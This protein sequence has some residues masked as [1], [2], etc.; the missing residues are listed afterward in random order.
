M[1]DKRDSGTKLPGLK[2]PLDSAMAGDISNCSVHKIKILLP[3]FQIISN[4]PINNTSNLIIMFYLLSSCL[5]RP[6]EVVIFSVFINKRTNEDLQQ[7]KLK[8][9][10]YS[11]F[12]P[13]CDGE[14]FRLKRTFGHLSKFRFGVLTKVKSTSLWL[15]S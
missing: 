3:L 11:H 7:V 9:L 4:L 5:K 2:C 6:R 12:I 15:L 8:V 13:F 14:I 10:H 1:N